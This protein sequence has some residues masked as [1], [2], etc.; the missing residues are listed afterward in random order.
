MLSPRLSEQNLWEK[1]INHL[2]C[3]YAIS[4]LISG[5]CLGPLVGNV[6]EPLVG[7]VGQE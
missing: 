1:K 7:N 3:S 2:I 4:K 5:S 6:V